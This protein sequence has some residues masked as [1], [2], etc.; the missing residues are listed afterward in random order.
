MSLLTEILKKPYDSPYDF[1]TVKP[2]RKYSEPKIF[3]GRVDVSKWNRLKKEEQ[4]KA[5]S[6]QWYVYYS[7]RNPEMGKLER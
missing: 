6:K 1:D 2:K 7:Y 3:T 5:L 4:Q